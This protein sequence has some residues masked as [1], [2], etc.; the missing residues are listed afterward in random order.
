MSAGVCGGS[1]RAAA[2][3]DIVAQ[4]CGWPKATER[5]LIIAACSG[6]FVTPLL[7]W[8]HGERGVQR[9]GGTELLIPAVLVSVGSLGKK[10]RLRLRVQTQAARPCR[11]RRDSLHRARKG[12]YPIA[13]QA[14]PASRSLLQGNVQARRGRGE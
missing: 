5:A 14:L 12:W 11:P 13:G 8:Y 3:A 7:P 9:A 1:V 6:F 2:D 4:R 10:S